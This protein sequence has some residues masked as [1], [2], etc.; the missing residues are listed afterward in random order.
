[1]LRGSGSSLALA[2]KVTVYL[3]DIT[4]WAVMNAIYEEYIDETSA[5]ARTT[6]EVR[7]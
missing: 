6:I 4:D 1:V 2:L 5:P 3:A 7:R